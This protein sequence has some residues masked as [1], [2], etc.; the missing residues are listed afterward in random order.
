VV[1]AVT[2]LTESFQLD[3]GAVESMFDNFYRNH[4]LPFILGTTGESAS[5]PFEL[6]ADY[7]RQAGKNKQKGPHYM[8]VLPLIASKNQ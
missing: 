8:L 4:V 6:K 3:H 7:V 5:L 2:P 1:P